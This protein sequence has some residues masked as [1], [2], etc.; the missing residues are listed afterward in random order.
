MFFDSENLTEVT[1]LVLE[2]TSQFTNLRNTV[3]QAGYIIIGPTEFEPAAQPLIELRS[4]AVYAG[5]ETVYDE[6]SAGNPDPMAIRTFIQWTQE[7]WHAP[8]PFA[9]LLP[10]RAVFSPMK[11]IVP[12]REPSCVML[13][14]RLP[15]FCIGFYAPEFNRDHRPVG[16][17][18][19][20]HSVGELSPSARLALVP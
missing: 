18:L 20:R 3:T 2:S 4:P 11:S 14:S 15:G 5:L 7:N 10:T 6:F 1:E 16:F 8:A 17:G 12:T 19:L 13:T 9:A